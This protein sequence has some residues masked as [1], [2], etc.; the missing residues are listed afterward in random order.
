MTSPLFAFFEG[1]S[2][3][4]H[5]SAIAGDHPILFKLAVMDSAVRSGRWPVIGKVDEAT[6][7]S[8]E[9]IVFFKQDSIS[10]KLSAYNP[11]TNIESQ[12]SFDEADSLECTAVWSAEH[13][14]DRLRDHLS[15][16]PNKWWASM[17]PRK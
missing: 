1:V 4:E 13:V 12:L 9:N 17:R 11:I 3:H 16:V 15:G 5:P 10:G 6:V 2:E 7:S 8:L 14:E